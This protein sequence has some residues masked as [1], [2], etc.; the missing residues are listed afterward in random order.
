MMLKNILILVITIINSHGNINQINYII[1]IFYFGL[2]SQE[3][4]EENNW[5]GKWF[6]YSPGEPDANPT[7]V[8]PSLSDPRHGI[9]MGVRD[10][11]CDDGKVT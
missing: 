4:S 10:N 7:Y 2:A 1:S 3:S 11:T 6:P 9:R 8:Q 5:G